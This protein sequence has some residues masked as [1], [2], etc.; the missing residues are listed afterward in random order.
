[1]N[2]SVS[3]FFEG[4]QIKLCRSSPWTLQL[5]LPS[6]PNVPVFSSN[7]ITLPSDLPQTYNLL[8]VDERN[9]F[10]SLIPGFLLD[11]TLQMSFEKLLLQHIENGDL[12]SRVFTVLNLT[13][14]ENNGAI[15]ANSI[16]PWLLDP[17][18]QFSNALLTSNGLN[19]PSILELADALLACTG[20]D[21]EQIMINEPYY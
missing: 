10:L 4:S 18:S 19:I 21:L 11:S 12:I 20:I 6:I 5:E 15:S 7:G 14:I 8:D 16:L 1:M 9:K 13:S 17:V 2:E 3:G